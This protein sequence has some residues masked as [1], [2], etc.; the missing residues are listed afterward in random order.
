M[1]IDSLTKQNFL[2]SKTSL[3]LLVHFDPKHSLT[4]ACDSSAYSLGAVRAHKYP[5]GSEKPIGYASRSLTRQ[6]NYSQIEK[7]GLAYMF[8]MN[9]FHSYLLGHSQTTNLC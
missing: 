2:A 9:K 5:D 6:K 1:A 3:C 8:D 4:L 7:E